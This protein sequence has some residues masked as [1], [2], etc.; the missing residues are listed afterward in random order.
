VGYFCSQRSL[1]RAARKQVIYRFDEFHVDDHS[2]ALP[3][4]IWPYGASFRNTGMARMSPLIMGFY[5][6]VR[7]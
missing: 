3:L 7:R 6:A 2:F 5:L 4:G 1:S